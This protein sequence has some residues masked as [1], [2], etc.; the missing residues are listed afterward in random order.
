MAHTTSVA[1]HGALQNMA[2]I[3]II[4]IIIINDIPDTKPT[5][6]K[7]TSNDIYNSMMQ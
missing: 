6:P 2:I 7:H 4:I 5:Q 1:L 3:I